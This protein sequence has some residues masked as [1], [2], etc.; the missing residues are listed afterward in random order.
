MS[1]MIPLFNDA[2]I[3]EEVRKEA[4]RRCSSTPG[5][6]K[7]TSPV[8]PSTHPFWIAP[9]NAN[10][11]SDIADG[12]N[13]A[14][15]T[16]TEILIIG[17]GITGTSIAR[18]ILRTSETLG[19]SVKTPKILMVD[20]RALV[21][22]ATGRNGGHINETGFAE[23]P[24][25]K[26]SF[27]K[28]AAVKITKFRLDH[29]ATILKVAEDEGLVGGERDSQARIVESHYPVFDQ[30]A[31][32]EIKNGCMEMKE[33][34]G[35]TV[36]AWRVVDAKTPWGKQELEQAGFA[37]AFGSI[38]FRAGA[39]WPYR[40]VTGLQDN[41]LRDFPENFSIAPH[42]PVTSIT[43]AT[44]GSLS[45]Q[46]SRGVVKAKHVVHATNSHLAHL[47]PELR[48]R[49]LPVRGQMSAQKTPFWFP[50]H[51]ED[52]LNNGRSWCFEYGIGFDYLTQLPLKQPSNTMSSNQS[53]ERQAFGQGLGTP[54]YE[55][56]EM[57]LGGGFAQT[58][59]RGLNEIG[60][61]DDSSLNPLATKHLTSTFSKCF[62]YS[63]EYLTAHEP[64]NGFKV[65]AMWT[66]IMGF[67]IDALPWVGRLGQRLPRPDAAS[68]KPQR[69]TVRWASSTPPNSPL[70]VEAAG[71]EWVCGGY[72][73]EGMVNAWGCGKALAIMLMGREREEK[74]FEWFP[75]EMLVTARRLGKGRLE[76]QVSF[77]EK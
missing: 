39:V 73:G 20:A 29:L 44:D 43:K 59:Y 48:G 40:L 13:V 54:A 21:S 76:D 18:Q 56:G 77:E 3:P 52:I 6:P 50:H 12:G 51:G 23:Y 26:E 58:D 11:S 8:Y 16:E 69:K 36:A 34:L 62:S 33:D 46:T 68:L 7:T 65:K 63:D 14:L 28:D 53:T 5:I 30:D 74:L 17:S 72:S 66:G 24:H 15:P 71:S 42:T 75:E 45:V 35:R 55:G 70:P 19:T 1:F 31:F 67:S 9:V 27:G 22:G 49:V 60:V 38:V 25:L 10:I 32:E 61:T 64:D 37:T 57:M 4:V 41:L 47:L 2:T